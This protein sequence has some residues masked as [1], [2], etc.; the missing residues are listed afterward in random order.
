MAEHTINALLSMTKALQTRRAQL[1]ATKSGSLIRTRYSLGTEGQRVDEPV[2][3]AKKI[4]QR[5]TQINNVIYKI[6]VK[7]KESNAR[8]AVN[9]DFDF[10][11]LMCEIA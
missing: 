8:T 1:E 11:A 4:D 3:D 5:I 6:D 9:L 7:I 2:Y 10:D